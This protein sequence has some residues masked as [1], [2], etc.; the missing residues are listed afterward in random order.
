MS[1]KRRVRNLAEGHP[2]KVLAY[3]TDALR[4]KQNGNGEN[5]L[6]ALDTPPRFREAEW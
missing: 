5:E 2:Q 3:E 1:A 4:E 6:R